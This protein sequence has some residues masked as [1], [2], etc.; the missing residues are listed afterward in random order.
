MLFISPKIY[1]KPKKFDGKIRKF[2]KRQKGSN[3]FLWRDYTRKFNKTWHVIWTITDKCRNKWR[4]WQSFRLLLIFFVCVSFLYVFRCYFFHEWVF[5]ISWTIFVNNFFFFFCC[6]CW[7]FKT[8][9]IPLK[10]IMENI[11]S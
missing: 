10:S 4:I 3:F 9:K 6:W 11:H 1:E 8:L 2:L 7:E 5:F